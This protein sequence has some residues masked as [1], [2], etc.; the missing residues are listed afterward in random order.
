MTKQFLLISFIYFI[1][2][3][4]YN[5]VTKKNDEKTA[6]LVQITKITMYNEVSHIRQTTPSSKLKVL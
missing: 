2:E 5:L 1:W 6:Q 3:S 4:K